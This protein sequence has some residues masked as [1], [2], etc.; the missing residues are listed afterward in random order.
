[1]PRVLSILLGS[2]WL[3]ASDTSSWLSSQP[4]S[5]LL[6]LGGVSV[7]GGAIWLA[8]RGNSVSESF[9]GAWLASGS[10]LALLPLA[11][12]EPSRRILGIA[13][14]GVSGALAL[15]VVKAVRAIRIAHSLTAVWLIL[16]VG[17]IG[18]VHIVAAA[19][20]TRRLSRQA[21][22]DETWSLDRFSIIRARDGSPDTTLVVRANYPDTVLWTPFALREHA[23]KRWRVLSQTFEQTVAIRNSSTS[24]D[25]IEEV[26]P[27][28]SLGPADMF[29]TIPFAAGD[30]VDV[31]GMRATVLRVDPEG[32]PKAVRYEFDKDLDNHGVSWISEG[33]SGFGDVV[34]PAV[35][36]GVR[37][38]P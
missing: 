29:R 27:L 4:T 20:E 33:T 7:V 37:L 1:M 36:I 23:P 26:G 17:L 6:I 35:G 9:Q 13:A 30:V 10:V 32:R 22:E 16:A 5:A 2:T 21:V 15:L 19:V 31:A 34:P 11:A 3:V 28:F 14:L 8:R 18:Y 25:V 38:A 24:L 12:T